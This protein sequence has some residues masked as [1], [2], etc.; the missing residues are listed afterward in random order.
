MV[1]SCAD[2][3]SRSRNPEHHD[4]ERKK[5]LNE[6]VWHRAENLIRDSLGD[7]FI[8]F[9]CCAAG[10]LGRDIG[11]RGRF[12][13]RA[14]EFLGATSAGETTPEPGP[15]SFTSGLIWA[16][17]Q[18]TEDGFT[19]SELLDKLTHAPDFPPDQYPVLR[20]RDRPSLKKIVISALLK[21]GSCQKE[22]AFKELSAPMERVEFL[23]LRVL[24]SYHPTEE[25]ITNIAKALKN[26]LMTKSISA[27]QHI[28]WGK[29]SAIEGSTGRL[30]KLAGSVSYIKKW[31]KLTKNK[32][33]AQKG[34]DAKENISDH[35]SSSQAMALASQ[36]M[37]RN[38]TESDVHC[39]S[40]GQLGT[41]PP[42]DTLMGKYPLFIVRGY[43]WA[44][45]L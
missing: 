16:L 27:V 34:L 43:L 1:F 6:I 19:T 13:H 41:P 14:F 2:S 5:M 30:S 8:I 7:V 18:L 37:L 40:S 32:S 23:D 26:T 3:R 25:D 39:S 44:H 36:D 42:L 20:E 12:A 9:D 24:L 28:A 31:R 35:A 38:E 29:L 10:N 4:S 33:L 17:E 22:K 45:L 15:N 21:D 11:V